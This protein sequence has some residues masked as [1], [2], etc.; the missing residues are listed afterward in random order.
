LAIQREIEATTPDELKDDF[1]YDLPVVSQDEIPSGRGHGE[2]EATIVRKQSTSEVRK[3]AAS[4]LGRAARELGSD[5]DPAK[6]LFLA[7]KFLKRTWVESTGAEPTASDSQYHI[8]QAA[9]IR[10]GM[11]SL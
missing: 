3:Q 5:A 1:G 2:G 4:V 7:S 11:E 9:L 6:T 10:E 8:L